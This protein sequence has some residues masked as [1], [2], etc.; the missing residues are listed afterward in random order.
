LHF[1]DY[2]RHCYSADIA[3]TGGVAA[4]ASIFLGRQALNYN[5]PQVL[6]SYFAGDLLGS[7]VGFSSSC[8]NN[9]PNAMCDMM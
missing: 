9:D 2:V 6:V 7:A 5:T 4:A 1:A 3:F 8:V